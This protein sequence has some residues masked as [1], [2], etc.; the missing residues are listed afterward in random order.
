MASASIVA[1]P[2]PNEAEDDLF[3]TCFSDDQNDD[4]QPRQVSTRRDSRERA[5]QE[6]A[7]ARRGCEGGPQG[8]EASQAA[9]AR[10]QR[11]RRSKERRKDRGVQSQGGLLGAADDGAG[12]QAGAECKL[13]KAGG[14]STSERRTST[15]ATSLVGRQEV[16]AARADEVDRPQ[17]REAF[18]RDAEEAIRNPVAREAE[19][20]I[21]T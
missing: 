4:V 1:W 5:R 15:A 20:K 6:E 17:G 7:E 13:R 16:D 8:Q 11:R 2:L 10:P 14:D 21:E 12:D 9:G 19:V 3:F 18:G